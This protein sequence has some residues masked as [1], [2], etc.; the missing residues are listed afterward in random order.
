MTRSL[1]RGLF[2]A[3]ALS[4]VCT[5]A[6][7]HAVDENT[8]LV[9]RE[10]RDQFRYDRFGMFVH[11]G[12]FSSFGRGESV[13]E[14]QKMTVTEYEV[15]ASRFKPAAFNAAE[16]AELARTA[17]ARYLTFT[18]KHR[19]GLALWNSAA[20]DWNVVKRT[21]FGRDVV[22]ELA[23]EC[24][25]REIKLFL[26]YSQLDW[27]HPDYY[28]RG[29]TGRHS[30]R[31]DRGDWSA[32]LDFMDAQL[33]ELM[34]G[35]GTVY[36]IWL[37]GWWDRPRADWRFEQTCQLIHS[38]QPW[39]IVGIN[40]Q[41]RPLPGQDFMIYERFLPGEGLQGFSGKSEVEGLPLE[42]CDSTNASW[43]YTAADVKHKSAR[44]LLHALVRA[45]GTDANFLLNV[46]PD[47][48][49]RIPRK[50]A[51]RLHRIGLWLTEHGESIYATRGGPLPLQP[52]GAT[53][54]R[55]NR[56]YVHV[57]DSATTSVALRLPGRRVHVA[58][59]LGEEGEEI[60]L[61][62]EGDSI[63]LTPPPERPNA[64]SRVAVLYTGPSR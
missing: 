14:E 32:Y 11:W 4:I 19:D 51:T 28:P 50:V 7:G 18:A 39:T 34:T 44:E 57:L 42:S 23:E 10:A 47:A 30:G 33:R 46:A 5:L 1:A 35:Y 54:Q 6:K 22:K 60:P 43:G 37:D 3:A 56:I 8:T 12:L 52:W 26:Y 38:L 62:A 17:G 21:P 40:R 55:G 27:H 31:P 64:L 45:A 9:L 49:G 41:L 25:R 24:R 20:S 29:R 36:G 15:A 63:T 13:M 16:W 61:R 2:L 59:T 58:R 48:D 53:T